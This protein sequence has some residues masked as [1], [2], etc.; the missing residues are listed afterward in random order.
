MPAVPIVQAVGTHVGFMQ[1]ELALLNF[2]SKC[3]GWRHFTQ[4]S[5]IA[6][7]TSMS[8]KIWILLAI[9]S[10]FFKHQDA[11]RDHC[12]RS[13]TKPQLWSRRQATWLETFTKSLSRQSSSD[14]QAMLQCQLCKGEVDTLEKLCEELCGIFTK[15]V[16]TFYHFY[17]R[18]SLRNVVKMYCS[19]PFV[20]RFAIAFSTWYRLCLRDEYGRAGTCPSGSNRTR[21]EWA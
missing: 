10:P 15:W 5:F 21:S 6:A 1:P 3:C 18:L 17:L 19:V 2:R 12:R 4:F 20:L 7:V 14:V 11:L 8:L 16:A 9:S 13:F